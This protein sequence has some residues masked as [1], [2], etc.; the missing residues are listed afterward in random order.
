MDTGSSTETNAQGTGDSRSVRIANVFA[1]EPHAGTPIGVILRGG[2]LASAQLA[3]MARELG[4]LETVARQPS[5][6]FDDQIRTFSP[7]G[8]VT[9]SPDAIAG[10]YAQFYADGR[11]DPGAYTVETKR[12]PVDVAV[13][14]DGAVWTALE[15][16]TVRDVLLDYDRVG[17]ALGVDPDAFRDIGADLLPAVSS[18]VV[19]FL[20]IPVNFFE[21]LRDIDPDLDALRTLVD[22]HDAIGVYAFTFDTLTSD[23]TIHARALVP[24]REDAGRGW[25]IELPAN[26]AAGG[27][28]GVYLHR[29]AESGRDMPEELHIEHG[30]FLDRPGLVG[31]QV[32]DAV[33][34]GGHVSTS[35]SGTMAVP[36]DTLE[37]IIEG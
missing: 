9:P 13:E 22:D 25:G 30:A 6:A 35:L 1:D 21:N 16:P 28:C 8:E 31:V 2:D 33:R 36:E 27:A 20:Q 11:V 4:V 23:A 24:E 26:G 3:T 5:D 34:V 7:D 15:E 32:T 12:G 37:D 29:I 14:D 10:A 17:E 18:A 19:P